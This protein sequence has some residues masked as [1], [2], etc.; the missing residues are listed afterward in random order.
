MSADQWVNNEYNFEDMYPNSK[1]STKI[2][3]SPNANVEEFDAFCAARIC[4]NMTSN[5]AKAIN[6][7]P[8]IDIPVILKV[9]SK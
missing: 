8:T 2:E 1:Y 9:V 6:E 3:V 5:T 4:G 7:A